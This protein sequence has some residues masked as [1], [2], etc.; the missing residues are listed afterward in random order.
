MVD[1]IFDWIFEKAFDGAFGELDEITIL[2]YQ[3]CINQH[4][5]GDNM[6]QPM[7]DL[8]DA[9][10]TPTVTKDDIRQALK[11]LL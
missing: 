2:A 10:T 11:S 4:I 7:L 9:N 8:F 6:A 5:K 3:K 1:Q